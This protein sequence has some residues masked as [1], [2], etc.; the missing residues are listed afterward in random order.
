LVGCFFF[1]AGL[2]LNFCDVALLLFSESAAEYRAEALRGRRAVSADYLWH[3]FLSLRVLPGCAFVAR[4]ASGCHFHTFSDVVLTRFMKIGVLHRMG[5][6]PRYGDHQSQPQTSPLLA[7]AAL[8][9]PLSFPLVLLPISIGLQFT[10]LVDYHSIYSGTNISFVPS[11][12]VFDSQS[13]LALP[14]QNQ[15]SVFAAWKDMQVM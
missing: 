4:G 12:V 11:V 9:I 13:V 7:A 6:R 1:D 8:R 14:N 15:H 2:G 3:S 10:G 5:L